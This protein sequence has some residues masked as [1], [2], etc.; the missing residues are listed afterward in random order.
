[1]NAFRVGNAIEFA[2][3]L[4]G[5]RSGQKPKIPPAVVA[6]DYLAQRWRIVK[7]KTADFAIG[8][9][10]HCHGAS[11]ARAKKEDRLVV[12]FRLQ[13][14]EGG[15]PGGRHSC[16]TRSPGAATEPWVIHPPDFD[17]AF[18]K[19]VGLGHDPAFGTIRVPIET[20]DVGIDM[21]ALL[22]DPRTRCPDF[23]FSILEKNGLPR[24]AV[25]IDALAG[26]KQN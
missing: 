26:G 15:K 4:Q 18:A 2:G 1:M 21:I 24:R 19:G 8:C 17:G 25:R 7:N 16:Q 10:V 6:Q 14:V 13:G 5:D 20:Q 3:N 12:S 9:D 22:R 23:Q 11:N